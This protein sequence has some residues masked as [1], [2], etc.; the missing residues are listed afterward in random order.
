[1]A[2]FEPSGNWRMGK[3]DGKEISHVYLKQLFDV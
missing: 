1:M 2:A 3:K